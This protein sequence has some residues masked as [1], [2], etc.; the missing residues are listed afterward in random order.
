ML[1]GKIKIAFYRLLFTFLLVAGVIAPIMLQNNA[2]V[3]PG[4]AAYF[5]VWLTA[6]IYT[7]AILFVV[8]VSSWFL[9]CKGYKYDDKKIV[10]YAGW[11]HHCLKVNGRYMDEYNTFITFTPIDLSCVLNDGTPL[12]VR[13]SLANRITLKIN[14]QLYR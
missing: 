11:F 12:Q 14:N 6:F 3:L 5:S 7:D 13:I 10:I 9:S 2:S 8:W 1:Y 4:G